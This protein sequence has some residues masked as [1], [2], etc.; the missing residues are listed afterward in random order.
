MITS[1][2]FSAGWKLGETLPFLHG[3]PNEKRKHDFSCEKWT[4]QHDT[5]VGQRKNLS[6][7]QESNPSPRKHR[8]GALSTELQAVM[9]GKAI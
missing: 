8:E 4:G 7:R 9:E 2:P 5:S 6:L 1:F 3:S